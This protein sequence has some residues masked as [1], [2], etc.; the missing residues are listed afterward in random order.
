M[1]RT[2]R[3]RSRSIRPAPF[4][5]PKIY[6]RLAAISTWRAYDG[7]GGNQ[8]WLIVGPSSVA[9]TG[10]PDITNA[11][12]TSV[13]VSG[14]GTAGELISVSI[15][16]SASPSNETDPPAIALVGPDGTWSVPGIDA[17]GLANGT[18]IYTVTETDGSGNTVTATETATKG[19]LAFT[20]APDFS[21]DEAIDLSAS[22]IGTIPG[23]AISVTITDG[24]N[25]TETATTTVADDG[26]W[27]VDLI[28]ASSVADGSVTYS[29]TETNTTFSNPTATQMANKVPAPALAFTSTPDITS[30]NQTNVTGTGEEGDTVSVTITDGTDDDGLDDPTA[31]TTTV[32]GGAWSVSGIDA[33]GLAVGQV[34]YIVTET[35]AAGFT[36]T[37]LQTREQGHGLRRLHLRHR[38]PR[39]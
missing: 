4:M 26:T 36:D 22:G 12:V 3:L 2:L 34:T 13:S 20:I 28:D 18:V 15:S 24:A 10:T 5:T 37:I 30:A 35:D 33:S 25:T 21:D 11:N 8:P 7:S 19:A 14:T 9:F 1:T 23:D 31:V 39:F 29:V 32:S 17:S 16:D 27:T 6:R 38:L